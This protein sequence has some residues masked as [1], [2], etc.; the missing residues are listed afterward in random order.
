MELFRGFIH[1]NEVALGIAVAAVIVGTLAWFILGR[2][3]SRR[4]L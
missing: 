2:R 1:G 3:A 4:D